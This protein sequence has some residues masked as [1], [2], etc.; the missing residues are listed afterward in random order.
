LQLTNSANNSPL[1]FNYAHLPDH[2]ASSQV[3]GPS[4]SDTQ[5]DVSR[6]SLV[7]QLRKMHGIVKRKIYSQPPREPFI[8]DKLVHKEYS[9]IPVPLS[10]PSP[11]PASGITR[12][13]NDNSHVTL[14]TKTN[15]R[16]SAKTLLWTPTLKTRENTGHRSHHQRA[17]GNWDTMLTDSRSWSHPSLPTSTSSSFSANSPAPQ[18]SH[19]LPAGTVLSEDT[20][21]FPTYDQGHISHH[22]GYVLQQLSPT[23]LSAATDDLPSAGLSLQTLSTNENI[24]GHVDP[25][26]TNTGDMS[27]ISRHEYETATA[28]Q[29]DAL[30]LR[31][32]NINQQYPD[33][34]LVDARHL[35][36]SLSTQSSA[37]SHPPSVTNFASGQDFRQPASQQLLSVSDSFAQM[38]RNSS[39]TYWPGSASSLEGWD[40]TCR[41]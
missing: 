34:G 2:C 3:S 32:P 28:T 30:F 12:S 35:Y 9:Q 15:R 19:S 39:G 22:L 31:S 13:P 11:L 20:S 14:K 4:I 17:W 10:V 40:G 23:S 29:S 24:E 37:L 8:H 7:I 6:P 41:L 5:T 38:N 1:L 33:T 21:S 36:Y 27:F 16:S 25:S 18:I 26:T